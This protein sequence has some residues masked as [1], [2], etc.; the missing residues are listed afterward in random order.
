MTTLAE[1]H[2]TVRDTVA[3]KR[4]GS[5]VFVRYFFQGAQ[6]P[7]TGLLPSLASLAAAVG[8][9]IGQ[10]PHRVFP[11]ISGDSPA[12]GTLLLQYANGATALVSAAQGTVAEPG[13]ASLRAGRGQEILNA[14]KD[15]P[16]GTP[17][18]V[19]SPAPLPTPEQVPAPRLVTSRYGILLV[20][21][22]H[23][24]QEN[25]A[26]AFTADPRCK[27][28]AVTDGAPIDK[29]RRELNERLADFLGVPYIADLA[30][31]LQ[32]PDVHIASI[33]APPDR[34]GPIAVRCAQ[35]GKHLYIDKPLAPSLEQADA[36]VAAVRGAGVRSHMFSL[37]T[38]P[39]A[40]AAKELFESGVLGR[41]L[42]IHADT[43]F[44]KG[45]AGTAKPGTPRREE[46]PPKRHQLL[47]AKREL[48]NIGVYPITMISWL[49]GQPFHTVY[50]VTGNYFFR[51]HQQHDVE[52]F[53]VLAG[54]LTTGAHV[55]VTAGR[56]GW[57]AHPAGGVNRLVL[58]GSKRTLIVDANRPRLEVSANEK[59]WIPPN[60][61]PAD[62]MGFWTSTQQEVHLQPKANWVPVTAPGP[63]DAAYFLDCL[64]AG[65]ES[66][67]PA[68]KA[69]AATEVI[70]AAYRS[71]ASGAVV[72]LPLP[73]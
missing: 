42:A 40:R 63:G 9:W 38:Q 5:P 50:A 37:I 46:Y 64:D 58:V 19:A 15:G 8:D 35:A 23:T 32:R 10:A 7:A 20:T 16:G 21:G 29:Q 71:A 26:A 39:W 73:R 45:P 36:I 56:V 61:N 59:P 33:C 3:S 69:A 14:L 60:I 18:A 28:I 24:H 41:L 49:T 12:Q 55:T 4:L 17:T 30:T 52:D 54:T 51:E 2:R 44:A 31:A 72:T 53:G 6:E 66:A 25:Y 67:L 43:F 68:A 34:R 65:R 1:L 48:D 13:V 47:E 62:P 70:L 22:G 57:M 27:L 11:L